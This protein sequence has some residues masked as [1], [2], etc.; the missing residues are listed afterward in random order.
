LSCAISAFESAL[1]KD[2]IPSSPATT[3][4]WRCS[5][6]ETGG[7]PFANCGWQKKP[8][9]LTAHNALGT[10]LCDQGQPA[11]AEADF[12][13]ALQIDPRSLYALNNMAKV[14]IEHKRFSAAIA[15]LK[16]APEDPDLQV[17]L[18]VVYSQNGKNDEALAILTRLVKVHPNSPLAHFNLAT[19]YANQKRFRESVDEYKETLRLDSSND[20]ARISLVKALA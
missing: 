17:T 19:I 2:P 8:D 4:L 20:V 12:M 10:A 5:K 7:A 11:A 9:L 3:S 15:Y 14:L 13:A 16:P 18:A 1:R 6:K